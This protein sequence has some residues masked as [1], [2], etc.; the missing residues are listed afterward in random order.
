MISSRL[1][2]DGGSFSEEGPLS[3]DGGQVSIFRK[4]ECERTSFFDI[5]DMGK[6]V[7]FQNGDEFF[8]IE[9]PALTLKMVLIIF[10]M[11]NLL[12]QC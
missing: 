1:I 9:F 5:V 6:E 3:Y 8:F 7:G 2:H 12:Q 11:T 10:M 4:I